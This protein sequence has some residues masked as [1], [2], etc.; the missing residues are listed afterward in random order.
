M[1]RAGLMLARPQDP[2]SPLTLGM[3][4]SHGLSPHWLEA[5]IH[6][7]RTQPA[8]PWLFLRDLI[9]DGSSM[10]EIR[11]PNGPLI[12]TQASVSLQHVKKKSLSSFPGLA[13]HFRRWFS[14]HLS[15]ERHW[16]CGRHHPTVHRQL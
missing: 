16:E 13:C 10:D 12:I 4:L 15:T 14:H 8:L 2:V 5:V 1:E 7:G 11:S 9:S 3:L 6:P